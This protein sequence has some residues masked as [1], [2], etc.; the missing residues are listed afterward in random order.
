MTH[1][2]THHRG[3]LV[4]PVLLLAAVVMTLMTAAAPAGGSRVT[5]A[6]GSATSARTVA[7][8]AEQAIPRGR[9]VG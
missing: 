9:K 4:R 1:A 5:G 8:A 6:M 2:Q 7:I 3:S